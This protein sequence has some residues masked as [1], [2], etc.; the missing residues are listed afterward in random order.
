MEQLAT[1]SRPVPRITFGRKAKQNASNPNSAPA[2]K[3]GSHGRRLRGWYETRERRHGRYGRRHGRYESRPT[4][5]WAGQVCAGARYTGLSAAPPGLASTRQPPPAAV[6]VARQENRGSW[7]RP[8]M[9]GLSGPRPR[10]PKCPLVNAAQGKCLTRSKPSQMQASMDQFGKPKVAC[11]SRART[12][13]PRWRASHRG[14]CMPIKC[15]PMLRTDRWQGG[16]STSRRGGK[17]ASNAPEQAAPAQQ[18]PADQNQA[19]PGQ[20]QQGQV[21]AGLE[22]VQQRQ[23]AP[24]P[25]RHNK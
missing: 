18:A 15:P 14:R 16:S 11:R 23:A 21:A 24:R 25:R 9:P 7:A 19:N 5:R 20:A 6:R 13:C 10:F 12:R 4:L 1:A 17:A 22:P 3:H 2:G 8:A